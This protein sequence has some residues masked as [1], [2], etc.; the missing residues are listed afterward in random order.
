MQKPDVICFGVRH[1]SPAAS[2]HLLKLLD[3]A[4]PDCV[5]IE[6]PSDA[7]DIIRELA[8]AGVEPPVAILA[9]TT[10][11]PVKSVVYPFAEYSPEYQ[12]VLWAVKNRA[13]VRFIDVPTGVSLAREAEPG[14]SD[15]SDSSDDSDN[16]LYY[17]FAADVYNQVARLGGG[18]D[19]DDYWERSFEHNLNDDV[20][21]NA[22][23]LHSAE[24]RA[25]LEPKERELYPRAC[26]FNLL[27]EQFMR[28]EIARAASE[29]G[30]IVVVTGAYHS[31]RLTDDNGELTVGSAIDLPQPR[32]VKLTLMPYTYYRLSARSGYGA[33]N[34]APMYFQLMWQM[35][36]QTPPGESAHTYIGKICR[37]L[38]EDGANASTASVIEAV[39][40]ATALASMRGGSQPSLRDLHDALINTVGE[41]D[42]ALV[43]KA[44]A[45]HDIGTGFGFLPEGVSQTPIQDDINREL[46][47][48]KIEKYKATTAQTLTLDL[49]E[50]TR[51]VSRDAAFIDLNRSTFFHRLDLLGIKFAQQM[52]QTQDSSW[53]EVWELQWSPE[54]EIAAV[55]TALRGETIEVAAAHRIAEMLRETLDVAETARL[56][57]SAYICALPD[58]FFDAV[59]ALQAISADSESFSETAAAAWELSEML[60]YGDLRNTDT[61]PLNP[62]LKQL[63]LRAALLLNENAGCDDKAAKIICTSMNT[64]HIISQ[65]FY[66][67][68]DDERWLAELTALAFRDDKNAILSGLSF[69]ILLERN[70]VGDEQCAVE[71]SRR[72]SPG[73][74]PD[75]G[76]G[77]F[78]GL[79]GRNRYSLLSR[80]GVWRALDEYIA[81]LGDDEFK[82]SL[83][84]LRR[85]FAD[86]EP[87][88]KGSIAELLGGLW[89]M[90]TSDAAIALQEELTEEEAES[91]AELN[92]FDF[93]F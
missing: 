85:S 54:V 50:N 43:V 27:R 75:V 92:D 74:P 71:V 60:Q 25:I 8:A 21:L 80:V 31:C 52:T 86:F 57:K 51:V 17:D 73:I 38:R 81:Q 55:E 42:S 5:L 37:T 84:F 32:N 87:R 33:G 61:A 24:L 91:L 53:R 34:P 58:C 45:E 70:L 48:L 13:E 23:K 88:E 3:S 30:K 18:I 69:A 47:R 65:Q 15:S 78:E 89:N 67:D 44:F 46:K 63:F 12:A 72:L 6:G 10:D 56:I 79:S 82:R 66:E 49:R 11:L 41:G 16:R 22:V 36:R 59:S 90:D 83:V 77:W 20:Y 64:M 19:Y 68:L 62:L 4:R 76:A 93:D 28:G 35:M 9:Y 40:L 26:E 7:N 39:R 14:N 1:L 29:Y 2:F